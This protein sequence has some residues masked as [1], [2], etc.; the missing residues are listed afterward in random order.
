M[1]SLALPRIHLTNAENHEYTMDQQVAAWMR[2]NAIGRGLVDKAGLAGETVQANTNAAVQPEV[3]LNASV[4]MA[5]RHARV[6][7]ITVPPEDALSIRSGTWTLLCIQG[8]PVLT[9]AGRT[10][11]STNEACTVSQ[12]HQRL[13]NDSECAARVS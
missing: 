12:E 11:A 1:R 2:L 4:V 10:A 9:E 8:K 6:S 3:G 7:T 13:V 5:A